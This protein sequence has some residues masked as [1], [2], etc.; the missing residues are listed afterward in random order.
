MIGPRVPF[1]AL[2]LWLRRQFKPN[3]TIGVAT[4]EHGG[5]RAPYSAGMSRGICA[6]PPRIFLLRDGRMI[7]EQKRQ[8]GVDDG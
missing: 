8:A 6:K 2:A 7:S 1:E 5:L 4:G 3:P